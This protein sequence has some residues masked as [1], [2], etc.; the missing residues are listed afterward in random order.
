[1]VDPARWIDNLLGFH[2]LPPN[3][4][5]PR[6]RTDPFLFLSCRVPQR[7]HVWIRLPTFPL[8]YC[9]ETSLSI[10][11]RSLHAMPAIVAALLRST[12]LVPAPNAVYAGI[13][14]VRS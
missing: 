1:M 12:C 4:D 6:I 11:E 5:Q 2:P 3:T 8:S 9:G 13:L 14:C 10:L 7:T